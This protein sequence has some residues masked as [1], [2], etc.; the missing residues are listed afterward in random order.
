MLTAFVHKSYAND[1]TTPIVHNERLEFV[2][3]GVLW[4]VTNKLLFSEFAHEAE[5]QLTLYKIALVREET[6]A[7]VARDIALWEQLFIWNGEERSEWR[8]KDAI[9]ADSFEALLWYVYLDHGEPIVE[10]IIRKYVYPKLELLKARK[11]KSHKSLVQERCQQ[12]FHILPE[13][14]TKEH[15][16][17]AYETVDTYESIVSIKHDQFSIQATWYGK[18]KKKAQEEAAKHLWVLIQEQNQTS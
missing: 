7:D 11:W 8:E 6:L 15:T 3:D 9:L 13:Y 4:A 18:N 5:S 14:D 16:R 10:N 12:Q 17:D 1:Y 2:G